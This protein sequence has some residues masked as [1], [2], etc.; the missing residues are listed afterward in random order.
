MPER[1]D[2]PMLNQDRAPVS[3]GLVAGKPELGASAS[4][5]QGR[6]NYDLVRVRDAGIL[7]APTEL[8]RQGGRIICITG[9]FECVDRYGQT[10]GDTELLVSHG[11][12]EDTGKVVILQCVHPRELGAVMDPD[13]REWVIPA[14]TQTRGGE[15]HA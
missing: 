10:T 7:D 15:R 9:L 1:N 5:G 2:H 12:D 6:A 4:A 8:E 13:L 11:V 14:P 3:A